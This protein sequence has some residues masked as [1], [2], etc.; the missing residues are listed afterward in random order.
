MLSV[1]K[2]NVSA[3]ERAFELAAS[4]KYQTVSDVCGK[5]GAEGYQASQ[6]SGPVLRKQ[7][8]AVIIKAN[9]RRKARPRGSTA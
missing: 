6:V 7:L 8:V 4:G 3:L 2:P 5:L 9:E 1:M